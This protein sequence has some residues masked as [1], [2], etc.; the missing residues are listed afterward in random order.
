M[1]IYGLAT[2]GGTRIFRVASE[3]FFRTVAYLVI[4]GAAVTG[5]PIFDE[6]R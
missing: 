6:A 4:A 2:F 5:S 3:A 1:P